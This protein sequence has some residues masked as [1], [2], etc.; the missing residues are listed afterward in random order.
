MKKCFV[1]LMLSLQVFT[2][3][4]AQDTTIAN[5]EWGILFYSEPAIYWTDI[6]GT[7]VE[8]II[9]LSQLPT[10]YTHRLYDLSLSPDS[11]KLAVVSDINPDDFPV[12]VPFVV[13]LS[14]GSITQITDS[15]VR[16]IGWSLDSKKLAYFTGSLAR[17][18]YVYIFNLEQNTNYELIELADIES[19]CEYLNAREFSNGDW[20]PDSQFLVVDFFQM[21]E[22]VTQGCGGDDGADRTLVTIKEDGTNLQRL[23]PDGDFAKLGTWTMWLGQEDTI[24]YACETTPDYWRATGICQYVMSVAGSRQVADLAYLLSEDEYLSLLKASPD[25]HYLIFQATEYNSNSLGGT[26]LYHIDS[27]SIT[28]LS[29]VDQVLGWFYYPQNS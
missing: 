29:V 18:P 12:F 3:S 1:L 17:N 8:L 21:A 20:S 23:F 15:E 25:G 11:S 4:A 28:E 7:T 16:L 6:S 10:Q 14:T 9:N 13:D 26:F 27:G 22:P 24:Y 5:G 19:T 2:L